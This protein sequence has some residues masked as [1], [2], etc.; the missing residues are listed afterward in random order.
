MM[1]EAAGKATSH[2]APGRAI[3]CPDFFCAYLSAYPGNTPV[4]CAHD[5]WDFGHRALLVRSVPTAANL[6]PITSRSVNAQ[7]TPRIDAIVENGQFS[8]A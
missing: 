5:E 2:K 4:S 3:G 8:L 1:S 7:T 6:T